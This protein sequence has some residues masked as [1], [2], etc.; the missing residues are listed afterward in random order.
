MDDVSH[1]H[2]SHPTDSSLPED[3]GTAPSASRRGIFFGNYCL[4]RS[5]VENAA[6]IVRH[7]ARWE[8]AVP[9]LLLQKGEEGGTAHVPFHRTLL[10]LSASSAS[11]ASLSSSPLLFNG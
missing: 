10:T 1:V 3:G 4:A 5:F 2:T 8:G 9:S 11:F 7:V 6:E